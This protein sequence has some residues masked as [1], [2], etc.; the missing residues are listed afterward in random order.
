MARF[1]DPPDPLFERLNASI[2]FDMRLAPYDVE[3]SRAHARALHGAGVLDADELTRMEQGLQTVA[4]ELDGGSFPL[5]GDEDVHMAIERRLTEIVGPLGGKLHTGRSRNDQVATDVALYVRDHARVARELAGSLMSRLLELAERHADWPMPGYTHLQRAQPVYLG[6]HLLAYFWMFSRDAGR[7]AQARDS[8]AELPLGSGALAGLNW[9]LD[10]DA[11]ARDLGFDSV[12]PNSIDAVS[13]RDFVL[14]YLAAASICAMH[15]SRLGAEI[16]LW[17]SDE[18]SFCEVAEG[19]S[20]GSS[21]M[22]QKKNP[23]AA[24]LLRAKAPR[25]TSSFLTLAGV[26]HGL[27][28]AYSKDLQEDKEALFDAVDNLELCLEAAERMLGGLRFHRERLAEAAADEFAA[29]TD[30]ADLLVRKGMPFREA[31][32]V[33]GGLV[34]DALEQ[35]KSALR[36]DPGG[37]PR[38]L[39]AARR[40]LLRGVAPRAMAGVEGLGRRHR[41]GAAG[42]AARGRQG[43]PRR[44]PAMSSQLLASA[45]LDADFFDR[46]VHE[47]ARE[48]IGCALLFDGVGGVIVECESYERDDPACHAYVGLTARTEPLF[49]PPGRAYVYLSYGVHPLLNFVCEPEGRA[50]A[51]LIRA[52]EPRWGVEE[53]SRRRGR[54]GAREL[55]SGPG[56][57]TEALGIGLEMDRASLAE[58]PFELRGRDD[59]WRDV[60]VATGPRIGISR[61]AELP[62]RFCAVGSE[63]LSRPLP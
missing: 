27:P 25:I 38:P 30:V 54:D 61:A 53:M 23:D 63:Y 36:A 60:A 48:L 46:S 29:A 18:F 9:D 50:A 56:K 57:L 5:E 32:G 52:L 19:F 17:S 62:W 15:L 11:V 4:E 16:V 10:R 20:S 8:A 33:V 39:G 12:A 42:R 13:N 2:G 21:I 43:V 40:L 59:G 26:M 55:C 1:R 28:L 58:P 45:R 49:G 22:P 35:G 7:F 14:D 37:A 41:L 24:E 31:H 44:D 6:H 47:V 34:R 3:Q 51:V